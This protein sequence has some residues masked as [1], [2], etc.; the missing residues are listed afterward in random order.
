M[1]PLQGACSFSRRLP[2]RPFAGDAEPHRLTPVPIQ[3]VVIEDDFWSPKLKVWRR[4]TIPD[5]FTKFENDR[6]GAINNFDRVR[7][8]KTGGHGGPA[9]YDGLIY[10]MIRGSAD[11]L[12]ARPTPA[13]EQRL[14]GYIDRIAAAAARDPDGYLNTWT[15]L[16]E[17]EHTLGTERR[18]RRPA[19]R[20]LQRRRPGRG[21]GPLLPRD[22]Q[23]DAARSGRQAR[24][25]HGRRHGTAAPQEHRARAF[26]GRG[27]AGQAL[28]PLPGP[29]GAE[30]PDARAGGREPLPRA[31]RVLDREPGQPRGPPRLRR[32]RPGP[33][34]GLAAG[35]HRGPRGPGHAPLR[36]AGRGGERQRP[37]R[38]SRRSPAALEQHGRAA[39]VRHRRPGRG[40]RAR[41]I[42]PRL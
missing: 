21:R 42:R 26:A 6:G 23:D 24:Q 7:D 22:R 19:A 20:C 27:G 5:C 3:Q 12:A 16:M 40:G 4:V 36:R 10:E 29:A 25:P 28:P 30:G 37:G 2:L 32:L 8:G 38:L 15:Q 1:I 13:L 17:P 31:G 11:F 9:W 41:R 39:D 35:D 14:D 18:Q 33:Q 34:A